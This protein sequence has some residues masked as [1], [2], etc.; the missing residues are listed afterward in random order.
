MTTENTNYS[1][2]G[3]NTVYQIVTER[4][5]AKLENGIAPWRQPW[6]G[7]ALP[8]NL[9]SKRRYRGIN[10]LILGTSEFNSPYWI[11]FNQVKELNGRI[12]KGSKSE[13]VVFWKFFDHDEETEGEATENSKAHRSA[14]L[15]YYRVFNYEQTEGLAAFLSDEEEFKNI[16]FEP[17]ETAA[18]I[19]KAMQNAPKIEHKKQSAY[20]SPSKDLINLPKPETFDTP[21]DYYA[22]AFHELTHSTGHETR[23]NRPG[24]AGTAKLTPFGKADYSKEEL[25]AELGSA[26]LC[27]E[28]RIVNTL[29]TS[30]D[31]IAGWLSVL[32]GDSRLVVTAASAAQKAAD[33]ILGLEV[34]QA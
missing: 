4:I 31:Y 27:A 24:V 28:S 18:E 14:M 16:Q 30:A 13:L 6:K 10:S 12:K 34:A 17:I 32:K 33:Y 9:V 25:I 7:E 11:T 26:F 20:Y 1:N 2:S 8:C 15:R 29:S 23:L 21:A 22:T 19:I 3:N 5:I